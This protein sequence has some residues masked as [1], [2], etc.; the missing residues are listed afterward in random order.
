MKIIT[1]TANPALDITAHANDWTRG[2]VNRGQSSSINA[3]GKGINVSINLAHSGLEVYATGWLG[4]DN[5]APFRRTFMRER[6]NDDFIRVDGETRLNIKIAD[7]N[8]DEN[9]NF[10][11]PGVRIDHSHREALEAYLEAQ[12]D[13]WTV[14]IFGGS[15][16]P[17]ISNN[18]YAQ[19]VEKYRDKCHFLVVD[20]RGQAFAEVLQADRLPDMIKPN[21]NELRKVTGKAL[22]CDKAIVNEAKA[23][24]AR[25]I[26]MVVVSMGGDGAWFVTEQAAVKALPLPV[27]V[28]TT[29]GAGDAMVAGVVRGIVVGR[30]LADIARTATAYSAANIEHVGAGL[31]S[32]AR[33]ELLKSQ[34]IIVDDSGGE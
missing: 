30:E 16:P 8:R 18:Y 28:A 11:M 6:I 4:R 33:L 24:L 13:E 29:V 3:G 27:D 1:V 15:L 7:Q 2:V 23:W 25:G 26:N 5:D 22:D 32:K 10:N 21:I 20:T 14:L 12:V 17:G 9:T 19:M 31:P 34:V